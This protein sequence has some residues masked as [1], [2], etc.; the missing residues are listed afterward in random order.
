MKEFITKAVIV[1]NDSVAVQRVLDLNNG[2]RTLEG[3]LFNIH[4]RTVAV[5]LENA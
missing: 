3:L 2:L 1:Q 4:P 5:S